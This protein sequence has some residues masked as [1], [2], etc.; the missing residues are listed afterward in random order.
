[1]GLP[2]SHTYL[3]LDVSDRRNLDESLHVTLQQ[4]L[5]L[6]RRHGTVG[7]WATTVDAAGGSIGLSG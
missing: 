6:E 2:Y 5:E 7:R 1:M 3:T 4:S